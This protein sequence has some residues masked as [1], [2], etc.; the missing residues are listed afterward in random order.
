M[1]AA[2]AFYTRRPPVVQPKSA[3]PFSDVWPGI[4]HLSIDA[5]ITI[6]IFRPRN[7]FEIFVFSQN[8][9]SLSRE[10]LT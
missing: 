3:Q 10:P 4:R 1:K 5:K 6:F 2:T 7:A 8:I 9:C